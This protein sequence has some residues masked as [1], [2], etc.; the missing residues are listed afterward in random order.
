MITYLKKK[1]LKDT[2]NRLVKAFNKVDGDIS[3]LR[4]WVSHLHTKHED[5]SHSHSTQVQ[6]SQKD[7][8]NIT[9]WLSYLNQHNTEVRRQV[10]EL[11]KAMGE[12]VSQHGKVNDRMA[13]LERKV[14]QKSLQ[15]IRSPSS[16]RTEL[17][18]EPR[19]ELPKRAPFEEQM[20]ERARSNR[21]NFTQNLILEMAEKQKYTTVQIEKVIVE[22]KRLS[23]RTTFYA[24]LR[25]MR[26]KGLLEDLEVGSITVLARSGK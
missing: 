17:R 25:E 18:T 26:A 19:T 24:Y 1:I 20:V 16:V 21:K 7:I 11:A 3:H 15:F 9:K 2:E 5:L 8:N 4:Q 13:E 6:L 22:E 14:A 23:G 10:L 12:F